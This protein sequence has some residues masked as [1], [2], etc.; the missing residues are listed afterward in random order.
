MPAIKNFPALPYRFH[1]V[2]DTSRPKGAIYTHMQG[3]LVQSDAR[4][5]RFKR[6]IRFRYDLAIAIQVTGIAL[7]TANLR[8]SYLVSRVRDS[9]VNTV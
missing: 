1:V 4:R 9:V 6:Q 3:C 8:S 2:D 5:E 7:K